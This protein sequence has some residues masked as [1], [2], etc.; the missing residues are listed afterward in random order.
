[1]IQTQDDLDAASLAVAEVTEALERIIRER[2]AHYAAR[3][4][5]VRRKAREMSRA[6]LTE[7]YKRAGIKGP[8][9]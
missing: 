3:F 8:T 4:P 5:A 6:E 2:H 7:A 9:P 1:M